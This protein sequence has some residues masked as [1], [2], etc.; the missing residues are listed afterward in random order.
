MGKM[1]VISES[2]TSENLCTQFFNVFE[3]E[4]QLQ[5]AVYN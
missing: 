5:N 4:Y 2:G 1:S 3:Y